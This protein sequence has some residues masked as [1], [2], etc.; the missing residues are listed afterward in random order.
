M[1]MTYDE[2]IEENPTIRRAR[3]ERECSKHGASFEDMMADLGDKAEYPA[4]D[5]LGWLGY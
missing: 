3:A 2:A 4:S 5:V 1:N